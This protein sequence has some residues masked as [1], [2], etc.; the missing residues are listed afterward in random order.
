[1][2][3]LPTVDLLHRSVCTATSDSVTRAAEQKQKEL[4]ALGIEPRTI[5]NFI[6]EEALQ[7]RYYTPKPYAHVTLEQLHVSASKCKHCDKAWQEL[8]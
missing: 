6:A 4:D 8:N 2:K 1:M 5:S 3:V 7:M